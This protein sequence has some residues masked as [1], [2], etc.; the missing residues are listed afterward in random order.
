MSNFLVPFSRLFPELEF[1]L[2]IFCLDD[3]CIDSYLIRDGKARKYTLPQQ[4][5]EWHWEQAR[6]KFGIHG[7]EIYEDEEARRFAE[8]GRME[9]SLDRWELSASGKRATPAPR[10]RRRNWWNR[11]KVRELGFEQELAMAE[12]SQQMADEAAAKRSAKKN[13]TH[14]TS[15]A[16]CNRHGYVALLRLFVGYPECAPRCPSA[17]L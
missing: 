14:E 10:R 7:D 11:P 12:I 4:R 5:N 6:K 3:D 8:E 2:V 16:S 13:G 9:E 1:K 15:S 17:K